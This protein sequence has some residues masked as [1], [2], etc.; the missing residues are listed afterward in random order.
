MFELGSKIS[1]TGSPDRFK[2]NVCY[3]GSITL[4]D[5]SSMNRYGQYAEARDSQKQA[6]TELE[7]AARLP[8]GVPNIAG[9]WASEQRVMTDPEGIS[10]AFLPLS[11]AQQLEP[12]EVPEGAFAFP[13]SRGTAASLAAEPITTAWS[14]PSPVALT[15]AGK[16]ALEGFDASSTDNPRLRC[17]ATNIIFDWTFDTHVNHI[18]QSE[19][20]IIMVYGFMDLER[21]IHLDR[22]EFPESLELTRSGYSIGRWENDVLIVAT[23]GFL[24]GVL[25]ADANTMH[26]EQ[27]RVVERFSLVNGELKREYSAEDALFFD[28]EYTGSDSLLLSSLPYESYECDDRSYRSDL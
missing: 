18:E 12:G 6:L 4:A 13:G 26:S 19:S 27:L 9:D 3:M 16:R 28:G 20:E 14:F 7:R 8:N 2:E 23:Q 1:I 17:E 22:Q 5:G 21:V 15:E 25:T 24:A 11:V 10:G